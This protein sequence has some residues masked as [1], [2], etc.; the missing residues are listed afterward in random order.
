MRAYERRERSEI[1]AV[2]SSLS[3][4]VHLLDLDESLSEVDLIIGRPHNGHAFDLRHT[5]GT[6]DI[7]RFE[8]E[9]TSEYIQNHIDEVLTRLWHR[10][11]TERTN[12]VN[13]LSG[14]NAQDIFGS[15]RQSQFKEATFKEL[16]LEIE[17]IDD[18]FTL[19]PLLA[20]RVFEDISF[21]LLSTVNNDESQLLSPSNTYELVNFLY[22]NGERLKNLFGNK[23]IRA[24]RSFVPDGVEISR[25]DEGF[26]IESVFEY[27]LNR[28]VSWSQKYRRYS[29]MTRDFSEN[30]SSNSHLIIVLPQNISP[31]IGIAENEDVIV[32]RAPFT[33][34]EFHNELKSL[35]SEEGY[36]S[37]LA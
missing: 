7:L 16:G 26:Q 18:V 32:L 3:G 22:P 28:D 9:H 30:I 31:R 33:K 35:V 25:S 27:S 15:Y 11:R 10:Q 24:K 12:E 8:Q 23:G 34:S 4:S 19:Y 13:L 6:S 36:S 20:G 5:K 17:K 21:G 29:G 37:I 2:L 14:K 1:G